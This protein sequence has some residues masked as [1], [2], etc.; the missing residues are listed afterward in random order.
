L[1]SF[2][3]GPFEL[4]ER[5]KSNNHAINHI[6]SVL[7]ATQAVFVAVLPRAEWL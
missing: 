1:A 7:D 4:A 5:E 2:L 6:E 3:K